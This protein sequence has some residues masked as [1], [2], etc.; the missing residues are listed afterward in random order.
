MKKKRIEVISLKTR[1]MCVRQQGWKLGQVY[2]RKI[3]QH[4]HEPHDAPKGDCFSPT[5]EPIKNG[6]WGVP[7]L[8][9]AEFPRV[10]TCEM[11]LFA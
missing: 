6:S 2:Y 5:S 8:N 1:S 7:S 11:A 4:S 3:G 9:P 10:E